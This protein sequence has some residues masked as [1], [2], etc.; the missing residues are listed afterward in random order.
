[1]NED[2]T[3]DAV[4]ITTPD[5]IPFC[6][7]EDLITMSRDKLIS[8]ARSLNAKLLTDMAIDIDHVLPTSYIRSSIEHIVGLRANVPKS[9]K[10]PRLLIDSERDL[11]LRAEFDMLPQTNKSPPISLLARRSQ[12]Q[13]QL[14]PLVT[15]SQTR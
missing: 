15:R 14:S 3:E 8:V 7:H 5:D 6:C 4:V 1:M 2:Y 11:R 12:S 9:P 10:A 13:G